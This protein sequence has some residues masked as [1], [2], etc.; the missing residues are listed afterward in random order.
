MTSMVQNNRQKKNQANQEALGK[1]LLCLVEQAKIA[2]HFTRFAKKKSGGKL[3]PQ[4]GKNSK[5]ATQ[6][7]I[8]VI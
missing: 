8:T 6:R 2:E 5:N 7:M 1:R 3:L 4:H